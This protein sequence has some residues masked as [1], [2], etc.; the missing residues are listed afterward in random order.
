MLR[1]Q[2]RA[3]RHLHLMPAKLCSVVSLGSL[4]S[5]GSEVSIERMVGL[6]N[7]LVSRPHLD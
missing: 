2:A 3:G 7:L 4:G 6:E 1:Q 5:L